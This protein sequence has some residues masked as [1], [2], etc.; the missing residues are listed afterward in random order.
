MKKLIIISAAVLS[1]GL[2]MNYVQAQSTSNVNSINAAV[3]LSVEFVGTEADYLVFRVEIK[4]GTV[5]HSVLEVAD[6]VEG[7]LYSSN[8]TTNTK[9]QTMK[10]E[11]RNNQVLDFKLVSAK[12]VYVKTFVTGTDSIEHVETY[13]RA[14]AGL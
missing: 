11:K 10:I 5:N 12:S 13:Q 8:I 6:A 7:E 14:V 9:F 4:T 2:P 1:V 3:P